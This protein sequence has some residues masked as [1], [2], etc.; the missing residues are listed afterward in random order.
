MKQILIFAFL[1]V[2]FSNCGKETNNPNPATVPAKVQ[3]DGYTITG[4]LERYVVKDNNGGSTKLSDDPSFIPLAKQKLDEYFNLFRVE[5][6][7]F[8]E[9]DK[10]AYS[11]LYSNGNWSGLLNYTYKVDENKISLTGSVSAPPAQLILTSSELINA[12]IYMFI[13]QTQGLSKEEAEV[14]AGIYEIN[15]SATEKS[16]YIKIAILGTGLNI[17]DTLYLSKININYK[18]I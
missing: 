5:Y 13:S 6:W 18:A 15:G 1:I 9:S 14:A 2:L 7:N 16:E 11:E 17:N 4:S 8:M 3:W 12:S 10:T